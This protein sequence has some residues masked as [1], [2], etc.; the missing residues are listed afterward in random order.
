MRKCLPLE[1]GTPNV[2]KAEGRRENAEGTKLLR[3][4]RDENEMD[5]VDLADG[6]RAQISL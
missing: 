2:K 3:G 1:G 4:A 6:G 5:A